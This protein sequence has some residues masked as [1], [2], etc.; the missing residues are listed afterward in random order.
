MTE[1]LLRLNGLSVGILSELSY[2]TNLGRS[3]KHSIGSFD[4]DKFLNE[5]FSVSVWLN[6]QDIL[7]EIALDYRVKSFDSIRSKYNRYYPD[8]PARQVF[9]DLLGFRAFC[10]SYDDL[11]NIKSDIFHTADMSSGKANDDGY[12]GVHLY[13]QEDNFHYP[14]EIQFNTYYDR[15]LNNW[16]HIYLYKKDYPDSIG[17]KMRELY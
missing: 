13:Y 6:E 8:K 4:K 7:Q 11:L 3:L 10:D 2:R 9:N 17:R 15:Q 16:L 1:D 14:I 12:R 5:L